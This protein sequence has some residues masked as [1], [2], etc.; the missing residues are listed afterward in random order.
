MGTKGFLNIVLVLSF[1]LS[2]LGGERSTQNIN[3][4]NVAPITVNS[5][6][7]KLILWVEK[8]SMNNYDQSDQ[9]INNVLP[10]STPT[11]AL[12]IIPTIGPTLIP[13]PTGKPTIT[14]TISPTESITPTVTPTISP[15]FYPTETITPTLTPTIQ[16]TETITPTVTPTV[17]P[18]GTITSTLPVSLTLSSYSETIIPGDPI[19]VTWK[20]DGWN[21]KDNGELVLTVPVGF[22]PQPTLV[23]SYTWDAAHLAV[24]IPLKVSQGE[25]GLNTSED[26][27]GPFKLKGELIANNKLI[28]TTALEFAEDGLTIIGQKGGIAKGFGGK[29]E[30]EFPPN[31]AV[32]VT[33]DNPM[34][35]R[36]RRPSSKSDTP[37]YLSGM[38]FVVLVEQQTNQI[39]GMIR[40]IHE[41][42]QTIT[43]TLSYTDT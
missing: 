7:G 36:I 21:I 33:D 5:L 17:Q 41:F 20:V 12:G 38:P 35:V 4:S 34:S 23:N 30:V 28:A 14:P 25:I 37:Y 24:K 22:A 32:G 13:E 2:G 31:A 18:T 19:S 15:T 16:P 8:F 3:Q 42:S 6:L 1:M 29:V 39:D 40:Q 11:P 10:T 9:I 27:R 26:A 43:I